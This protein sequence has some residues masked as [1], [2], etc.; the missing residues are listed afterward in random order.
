MATARAHR[1][2]TRDAASQKAAKESDKSA[3]KAHNSINPRQLQRPLDRGLAM[4]TGQR[5]GW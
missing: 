4:L 3:P 1:L 2:L 5:P